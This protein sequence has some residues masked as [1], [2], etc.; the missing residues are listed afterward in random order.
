VSGLDEEG[1]SYS[2]A[3][4]IDDGILIDVSESARAAG[5]RYPVAM[6]A[7]AWGECVAVP[8]GAAGQDEA[9][10][11]WDVLMVLRYAIRAGGANTDRVSFRVSVTGERNQ[12]RDVELVS[13]CGPG[14]DAAPVITIMLPSED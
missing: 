1:W 11:L 3:Q 14:D 9:G 8:K 4:A 10:R 2:R 7:G 13:V 6:T 5:F 12:R